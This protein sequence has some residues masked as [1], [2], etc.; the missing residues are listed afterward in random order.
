MKVEFTVTKEG[1]EQDPQVTGTSKGERP[2]ALTFP[3]R[4]RCRI[5][6]PQSTQK[7]CRQKPTS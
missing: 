7:L 2:T 6:M 3:M 5:N 4:C 1:K